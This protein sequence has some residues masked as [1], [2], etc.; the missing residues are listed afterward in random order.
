MFKKFDQAEAETNSKLSSQMK[1]DNEN[2]NK[3]VANLEK[4]IEDLKKEPTAAL[5]DVKN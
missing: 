3:K 4:P 2:L 5:S 1:N